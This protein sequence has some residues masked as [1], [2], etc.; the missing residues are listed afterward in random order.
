MIRF[1]VLLFFFMQLFILLKARRHT[2]LGR[3]LGWGTCALF[4]ALYAFQVEENS[5]IVFLVMAGLT[6]ISMA[7]AEIVAGMLKKD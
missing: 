4:V 1:A 3:V 7:A 5:D 2:V 6:G